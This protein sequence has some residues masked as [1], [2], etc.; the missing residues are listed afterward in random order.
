MFGLGKKKT[1][2]EQPKSFTVKT[3]VTKT[4]SRYD[5]F[6]EYKIMVEGSGFV[7]EA[8]EMSLSSAFEKAYNDLMSKVSV[9]IF[10]DDK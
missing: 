6:D 1:E 5:T 8:Q 10:Q 7:G 3:T 2:E 9:A 4:R